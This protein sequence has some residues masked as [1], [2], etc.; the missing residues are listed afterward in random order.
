MIARKAASRGLS[1]ATRDVTRV[2]FP[3]G[4]ADL[5]F[6][7]FLLTHLVD[8]DQVVKR[9]TTQVNPG[10]GVMIEKTDA[11]RTTQVVFARHLKIVEAMLASQ[12][13]RLYPG[14]LLRAL[15]CPR[16]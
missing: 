9:W 5:I 2:P 1:F 8:P 13:I 16:A 15:E 6:Y 3:Y 12:C 14:P 10:G 11:I 7:R 4:S